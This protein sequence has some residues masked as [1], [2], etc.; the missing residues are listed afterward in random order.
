MENG[1]EILDVNLGLNGIDEQ[2]LMRRIV[3]RLNLVTDAV[4]MADSSDPAVLECAVRRTPGK[5]VINSVNGS[6]S[7]LDNVLPIAA[8]YGW[9]VIGLTLDEQGIPATVEGRVNIAKRIIERAAALGIPRE[10]VYIDCL[11]MAEAGE[12]GNA[13]LTLQSHKSIAALGCHTALGLSNVSFG[14]PRREELNRA[15]YRMAAEQGLTL[16]IINPSMLN[17]ETSQQAYDFLLNRPNSAER[18]I[19][20]ADQSAVTVAPTREAPTIMS[21]ILSGQKE[22]AVR[23]TQETLGD[24]SPMDIVNGQI[25]PAL[26]RAGELFEKGK[27]FLPQLIGCA[28][29]ASAVFDILRSGL[30]TDNSDKGLLLLATVKGDIHEIGKNIVKAVVENYGYRV[31]DLGKDVDYDVIIQ[32]IDD[33]YPCVL[34]LS[35]LM[36]TTAENMAETI[37]RVRKKYPNI[38]I[39]IGGAVITEE[40]AMVNGA[41]YCHDAADTVKKMKAYYG[42]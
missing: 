18:Y 36:T 22:L 33:H 32:A 15:F 14:M 17:G 12:R 3:D 8:K 37:R 20:Y 19:A 27:Y 11:T 30:P 31:I 13:M 42:N 7:S 39:L 29:S 1:A 38:E 26:D 23:L 16:A 34:G 5:G 6:E 2:G 40:F 25:I 28:D 10:D 21:A 24:L 4:I 41:T 35:A 9:A